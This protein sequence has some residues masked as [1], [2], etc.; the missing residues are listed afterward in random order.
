MSDYVNKQ[1]VQK[2]LR[3]ANKRLST[4]RN[5]GLGKL[6]VIPLAL[7]ENAKIT[8]EK[9]N[10]KNFKMGR[11]PDYKRLEQLD[12][13][14]DKFLKSKWTTQKGRKQIFDKRLSTIV[15]RN[16]NLTIDRA[17][18]LY[19]VFSTDEYAKAK[20]KGLFDSRQIIELVSTTD[21]NAMSFER[22]LNTVLTES[23]K[24]DFDVADAFERVKTLMK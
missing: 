6:S 13:Q 5:R 4:M 8:G 11:N 23:N 17:L 14:L 7:R 20:E 19:D 15:K 10:I 18:V 3:K 1:D 21:N 22:A 24:P 16:D 2:K 12:K 9:P